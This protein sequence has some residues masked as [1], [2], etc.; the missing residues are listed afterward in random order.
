MDSREDSVIHPLRV[1]VPGELIPVE[2][3]DDKFRGVEI[4]KTLGGIPLV[5][6]NQEYVGLDPA[7]H[8]R[9]GQHQGGHALN[10]VGALLVVH[11]GLA[12]GPQDGGNHLHSGGFAVGAGDGND[13]LRQLHPG[14]DIRT[15]LQGKFARHGT[16]LAH[17]FPDK[18]G[19]LAYCNC[20]KFSHSPR[21]FSSFSRSSAMARTGAPSAFS[22]FR[23]RAKKRKSFRPAT[24]FRHR[25]SMITIP[26][27]RKI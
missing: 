25:H 4:L 21:P 13:V 6:L 26:S 3:G 15:D 17:Q 12:P 18:P 7:A 19:Q 9:M 2:V 8:G 24:F 1:A 22:V 10:L 23:G 14:Q 27:P 16:A 20:Q 11:H 5:G